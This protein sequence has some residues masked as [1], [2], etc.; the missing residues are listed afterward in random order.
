VIDFDAKDTR[1]ALGALRHNPHIGSDATR[2]AAE[3]GSASRARLQQ[4]PTPFITR[5]GDL[6]RPLAVFCYSG[7]L[8]CVACGVLRVV[9]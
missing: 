2:R 7:R 8:A 5:A 1:S 4:S 9:S 6:L 3:G